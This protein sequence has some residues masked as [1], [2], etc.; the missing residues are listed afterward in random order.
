MEKMKNGC[1]ST[2]K[3]VIM[4]QNL[5]YLIKHFFYQFQNFKFHNLTP[6]LMYFICALF[7]VIGGLTLTNVEAV[8]YL[9]LVIG[10]MTTVWLFSMVVLNWNMVFT[11]DSIVKIRYI[12]IFYRIMPT[13]LR[14]EERRV[15][16]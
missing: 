9:Y 13:I 16:Q 11:K 1:T 2:F 14:S 8:R 3:E 6:L 12:S 7:L 4:K 10:L 5:N 15:G